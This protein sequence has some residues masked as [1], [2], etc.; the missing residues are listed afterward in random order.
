MDVRRLLQLDAGLLWRRTTILGAEVAVV[1]R[2]GSVLWRRLRLV[3]W[4]TVVGLLIDRLVGRRGTG[5]RCHPSGAGVWATA[6]A[7]TAAG[8]QTAAEGHVIRI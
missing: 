5:R 4:V 7:A 6:V 3:V 2:V 8:I 1:L